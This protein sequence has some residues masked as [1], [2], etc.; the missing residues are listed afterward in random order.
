MAIATASPAVGPLAG[1][2]VVELGDGTAGPYA[3]KMLGDFGAEVVKVE[4]P[5]GDSSRRRGPFPDGKP[6]PEASGLYLY[7]NINKL[8]VSFDIATPAGRFA[9]DRLLSTADIFISNLPAET[10]R[11]FDLD[12][13]VLRERYPQLIVTTISPFG[14]T[15]PW[16]ERKGDELVTYAMSG[17]A[18]STPGMP[19]AAEDLERE[20]PLHPA[21]FAAET[22]GKSVV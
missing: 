13:A 20:L 11:R 15:G 17:M 19:D 9:I 22:I 6:D 18:Y 5:E 7:L 4:T 2:S 16:A 12:P 8:G 14:S 21:A 1:L 10:L 3:A